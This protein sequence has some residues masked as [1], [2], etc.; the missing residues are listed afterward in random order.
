MAVWIFIKKWWKYFLIV[1]GA[2]F[3]LVYYLF[4]RKSD[5]ASPVEISTKLQ[6][7]LSEVKEKRHDRRAPPLS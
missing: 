1:I 5:P 3:V 7:G 2:V 6:E 4:L